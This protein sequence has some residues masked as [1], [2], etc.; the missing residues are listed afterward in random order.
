MDIDLK[1]T[2]VLKNID[3]YKNRIT[4]LNELKSA[5]E[6]RDSLYLEMNKLETEIFAMCGDA[7]ETI[8]TGKKNILKCVTDENLIQAIYASVE[9]RK[10][11]MESK[12]KAKCMI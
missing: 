1:L 2:N 8:P 12:K 4:K 9:K 11:D 7:E 10:A 3:E 6:E 5:I